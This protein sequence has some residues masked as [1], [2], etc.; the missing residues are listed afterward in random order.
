MTAL[1]VAV[2]VVVGSGND[3]GSAGAE[4]AFGTHYQGLEERRVEAGVPTMSDPA[5]GGAHIHP[6]LAVYLRGEQ[7]P[8]PVNVGIDPSRPAEMMAGL[9]TH[10]SS[11]VIHVENAAEPTLGQFFEIWGVPLSPEQLGPHAA[12]GS[13][14][15]RMWVDGQ[16]SR[17]FGDLVLEDGQEIVVAHGS[18]RELPPGLGP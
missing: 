14:E 13:E 4:G 18:E 3:S 11:G 2:V 12:S 15:V 8:I 16:A 5:A 10:D 1:L 6:R 7:V 17:D 9:H